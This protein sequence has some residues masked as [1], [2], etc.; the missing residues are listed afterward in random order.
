MLKRT[1]RRLIPLALAVLVLTGQASAQTLTI[2]GFNVESGAASPQVIANQIGPLQDIDLWGF[3][4]VRNANDGLILAQGAADGESGNFES[5]LGSTGGEDR[6][7]IVYNSDRLE[8]IESGEINELNLGGNVRAPLWAR[9]QVEPSGP[10]LI[11]MVNHLYRSNNERRHAQ[12]RGLNEWARSQTLPVI[13]T[14][15]YNFDWHFQTGDTNH[16]N[17]YDLMT[18][19]GVFTWVRPPAPLVPTNCSS[20]K[21]VL[22]FFFVSGPAQQWQAE[23]EILFPQSSYCPDSS[24]TSDHRPVLARFELDTV[25]DDGGGNAAKEEI[26]RKIQALEQEL[27]ALKALVQALS[28][29]EN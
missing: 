8:L 27:A 7:L 18:A 17:G 13:A 3:S 10:E 12:A 20:H 14:G 5:I 6:L 25:I 23:S 4:E 29:G 22:D 24:T 9:F 2:A 11:F 1:V 16:D 19:D 15:D 26:L 21:S 28:C